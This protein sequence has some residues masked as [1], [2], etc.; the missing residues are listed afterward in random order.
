[1]KFQYT[2]PTVMQGRI[3]QEKSA[4][5]PNTFAPDNGGGQAAQMSSLDKPKQR[6]AGKLGH[7]ALEYLNDPQEQKRTENWMAMFGQ[8]VP[9]FQFNMGKMMAKMGNRPP[10]KDDKKEKKK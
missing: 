1:M 2:Q 3:N 6:M 9:G 10:K 7:R 4:E 8:S 5:Q